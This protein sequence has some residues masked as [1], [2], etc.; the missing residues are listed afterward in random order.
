MLSGNLWMY[1]S[2]VWLLCSKISWSA[3]LQAENDFA[4]SVTEDYNSY[5]LKVQVRKLESSRGR[6]IKQVALLIFPTRARQLVSYSLQCQDLSKAASSLSV[7]CTKD[8][9]RDR[10]LGEV[11]RKHWVQTFSDSKSSLGNPEQQ[12][13]RGSLD[14]ELRESQHPGWAP[15]CCVVSRDASSTRGQGM[16]QHCQEDIPV[17]DTRW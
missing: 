8:A 2:F 9:D 4:F 5:S 10:A 13:N 7:I 6:L 14:S 1:L 17:A 16:S 12:T 11:A 3:V 15:K